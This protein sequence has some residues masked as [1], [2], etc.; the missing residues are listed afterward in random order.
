MPR[1]V[2]AAMAKVEASYGVAET[3]APA[4]DGVLLFDLSRQPESGDV[5][6]R[7][8]QQ[9]FVGAT[10]GRTAKRRVPTGFGFELA[11]S[12]SALAIPKWAFLLRAATCGVA[13][14]GAL[15]VTIPLATAAPYGSLT[16]A[17]Y[18]ENVRV[19]SRG[20]R[21]T[22]TF[23]FEEGSDP[24]C[25]IDGIGLR[26]ATADA[27]LPGAVDVSGWRTPVEVTT[28]NTIFTLDSFSPGLR[29]ATIALNAKTEFD[30]AVG[31][32]EVAVSKDDEG[33]ARAISA[34]F[35][36]RCPDLATKNYYSSLN[37]AAV[38]FSLVHG[39]TAGNIIEL[40]SGLFKIDSIEEGVTVGNLDLTIKGA[41][42]PTAAGNELLIKTR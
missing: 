33:D 5:I 28:A 16:L 34:E 1:D 38:A 31:F 25:T 27:S 9:P 20:Y 17:T 29:R 24:Y 6:R 40:S 37:G 3:L 11:G 32:E 39:V 30:S 2:V 23:T 18:R 14:V 4:N 12:G 21:G 8:V 35:V 42:V 13:T 26:V 7:R 36:V 41:C 15:E 22:A 10:G 19:R